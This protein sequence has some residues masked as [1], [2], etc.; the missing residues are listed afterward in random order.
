MLLDLS[1]Y[2][3]ATWPR[4]TLEAAIR[5]RVQT[6]Y[7][8]DGV[9]LARVL[10]RHK[11]FLRSADRG[12]A[13]NVMLDG[14]WEIWLT[15]FLAQRLKPGM[16]VI[17]VGANFGYYTLLM[18][19]AVGAAGHVLAVEP[20]PEAA[21]LLQQTVNL[22][23][24][25]SRTRLMPQALGASAGSAWLYA[26]DGE[27]KNA[28]LV[29]QPDLP[30]GT[31]V[32]V[33]TVPLDDLALGYPRVDLVKIDA[34]GGEQGI[35][36]GMQQLIARDRPLIVLEFNAARYADPAALLDSLLA[37]YGTAVE[38]QP[39]GDIV[40]LDRPSVLD[41]ASREDRLLVFE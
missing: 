33:P 15:Q 31:T 41:Q 26:P 40:A 9:V 27:P 34:E 37:H 29:G 11:M 2:E 39:T 35:V 16:T 38:L 14:Y 25:A 19:E 22:A 24:H 30:G 13:C 23:G 21:A 4:M 8:G 36:A 1:A 7:L 12:F 17:D 20:N 28:G 6:A 10:G 32:E 5:R 18:G 3:L